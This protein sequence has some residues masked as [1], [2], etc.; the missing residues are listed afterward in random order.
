M[1]NLLYLL[2]ACLLII[3]LKM[4]GSPKTA[5]RGNAI[6]AVGMLI[7]AG[8]ALL[9]SRDAGGAPLEISREALIAIGVGLAAG[10]LVG[11]I[12]SQ[13]VQMTAMPQ[14]VALFN[15]LGGAASALVATIDLFNKKAGSSVEL[16]LSV[17]AALSV[18]IGGVTLTGSAIAFAKLQGLIGGRPLVYPLQKPLNLLLLLGAIASCCWLA[19]EPLDPTPLYCLAGVAAILGVLSV[20]PIGGA[21]MPVVISLLNSYSGLAASAA[22]FVLG[23]NILIIAGSLVG[24]SGLIL[25]KIMCK[26]MNR[27]LANVL[28]GAF[29][30]APEGAAE[31]PA[32]AS[33][34]TVKSGSPDDAA[35]ILDSAGL[36][37]IVPGYGMAVAQ[38][39]HATREMADLLQKNS[40]EVKYAIHP[41][42]GRMPGHMN[43]LL[44][45]ADVPY[46]QLYDMDQINSEF[47]QADVALVIGANDVT[48]PAAKTDPSS[49]IYG[50][51]IL[52]VENARTVM[53]L[54]RSMN[55][56]FAGVD[57][58]LYGRD[59]TMMIF[60]DA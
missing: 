55:P 46:D 43:V 49:P 29:G 53:V 20:L 54:K 19:A 12:A 3:G 40:C 35:M 21:D 2:S 22:G 16:T 37:I 30:K 18:L 56:G 48:N 45:E 17:P 11:I 41:V 4:L 13:K 42:A 8:V 60:G 9:L 15:G 7:A 58:E 44:A 51:P 10:T 52:D 59:N 57:N 23:N 50:M 33:G 34:G 5:V 1:E 32:T 36:V 39:Q 28:F 26:A 38:A 25:T 14:M 27:S 24:A 6:G 31:A 47:S